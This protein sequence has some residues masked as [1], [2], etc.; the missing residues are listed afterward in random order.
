MIETPWVVGT[1]PARPLA[2]G[3]GAEL[4][5]VPGVAFDSLWSQGAQVEEWRD[6]QRRGPEVAAAVVAVWP[7]VPGPVSVL[8]LDL[9][10]WTARWETGF[11]LWFAALS[12]ACERCRQ[13]GQVVAVTDR[14]EAKS[15]AGCALDSALADAVEVMAKSLVQVQRP[16]GVRVNVVSTSMRLAEAPPTSWAE[17]HG[18][19]AMLL[20]TE[21]PGVNAAVIRVES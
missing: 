16:R 8:D 1:R 19:V 15:S 2:A 12:V 9:D 5:E 18:A 4:H 7:E 20:T 6:R 21:G 14:P 10:A 13:G 3:L 11:A 17:L